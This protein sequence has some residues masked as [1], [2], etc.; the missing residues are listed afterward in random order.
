MPQAYSVHKLQTITLSAIYTKSKCIVISK[1]FL[2]LIIFIS[3]FLFGA[4]SGYLCAMITYM[5]VKYNRWVSV[6]F[7]NY[8]GPKDSTHVTKFQSHIMHATVS[9][10]TNPGLQGSCNTMEGVGTKVSDMN[11]KE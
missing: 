2:F 10:N 6:V 5:S 1:H 3:F 9:L 8:V 4:V 7:F 11:S